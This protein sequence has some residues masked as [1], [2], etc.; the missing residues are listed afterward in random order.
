MEGTNNQEQ[1]SEAQNRRD[2]M[3][4]KFTGGQVS[5]RPRLEGTVKRYAQRE[6]LFIFKAKKSAEQVL[7]EF[8][9]AMD[10]Q[11][12]KLDGA[13]MDVV[14]TLT[15]AD[16]EMVYLPVQ[17][18]RI[19][20]VQKSNGAI[21]PCGKTCYL[22]VLAG[23]KNKG[24]FLNNY[25]PET[26]RV[27]TPKQAAQGEEMEAGELTLTASP[28]TTKKRKIVYRTQP[29]FDMKAAQETE[30]LETAENVLDAGVWESVE[31]LNITASVLALGEK[32]AEYKI[33]KTLLFPLWVVKL[34]Y[35]GMTF[36]HYLSD[37]GTEVSLYNLP[38]TRQE[39]ERTEERLAKF[40]DKLN[41][42]R[43]V[44]LFASIGI[45]I[46]GM[47]AFVKRCEAADYTGKSYLDSLK[48]LY[49]VLL[50]GHVI[51]MAFAF[52]SPF[53]QE[54]HFSL[55]HRTQRELDDF[56]ADGM[57]KKY[58]LHLLGVVVVLA[59]LLVDFCICQAL[60]L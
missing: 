31:P 54:I 18:C 29:F 23:V 44:M 17:Y 46:F 37:I 14:R 1:Y 49:L 13:F 36:Y 11:A 50:I 3:P 42:L 15:E 19:E 7:Q 55:V 30:N 4:V 58:L 45:L 5:Y 22:S 8:Q 51:N 34:P 26:E 38:W 12:A 40:C 25:M 10:M 47:V 21:E 32:I 56:E 24:C 33:L 60:L 43:R 35:R 59:I 57:M 48:L 20:R 2:K 6:N 52:S 41:P 53:N 27:K 16:V 39:V 28:A 9:W